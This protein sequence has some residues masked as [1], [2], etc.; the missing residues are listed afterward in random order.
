M[1]L[2][3]ETLISKAEYGSTNIPLIINLISLLISKLI[4][5]SIKEGKIIIIKKNYLT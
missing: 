5:L 3:E 2:N 1:R 4:G